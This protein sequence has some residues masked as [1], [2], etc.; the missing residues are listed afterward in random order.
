MT[1]TRAQI[2]VVDDV[3]KNV[4]LLADVLAVK[5][6]RTSTAAVGRGGAGGHRRRSGPTWC[7]ST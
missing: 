2:L 7:C 4:K 1:R 3:A 6:Y 5:G